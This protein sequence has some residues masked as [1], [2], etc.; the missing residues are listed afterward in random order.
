MF[1]CQPESASPLRS[2]QVFC[3]LQLLSP[4][5]AV[6]EQQDE[7]RRAPG[8]GRR[9]AAP[10][11]VALAQRA[12]P[13]AAAAARQAQH[14]AR[15]HPARARRRPRPEPAPQPLRALAVLLVG[16]RRAQRQRGLARAARRA[17]RCARPR[18]LQPQPAPAR[19][20]LPQ[21]QYRG[22]DSRDHP[23]ALQQPQHAGGREEEVFHQAARQE[24][25]QP[26]QPRARLRPAEHQHR[27]PLAGAEP[28]S[29]VDRPRRE[30]QGRVETLRPSTRERVLGGHRPDRRERISPGFP[31]PAFQGAA[32]DQLRPSASESSGIHTERPISVRSHVGRSDERFAAGRAA[33]RRRDDDLR[34]RRARPA[35][36]RAE[37]V[38]RLDAVRERHC[39]LFI[40]KK[41]RDM[42]P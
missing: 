4:E 30:G 27:R 15:G 34:R 42:H 7:R 3:C 29:G 11:G 41:R 37:L 17:G 9:A 1:L 23:G 33:G 10:A 16:A 18:R 35:A 25:Y 32:V 13:R 21:P 6:C 39:S 24:L 26:T 38:L 31:H 36:A 12:A 19:R 22:P 20:R 2:D 5:L 40:P 14:R 28:E 8:A